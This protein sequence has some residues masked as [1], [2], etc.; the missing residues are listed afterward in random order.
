MLLCSICILQINSLSSLTLS[1]FFIF[2]LYLSV[3]SLNEQHY[4]HQR[5]SDSHCSEITIARFIKVR[6]F[7]RSSSKSESLRLSTVHDLDQQGSTEICAPILTSKC[8]KDWTTQYTMQVDRERQVEQWL[9]ESSY[10]D[11]GYFCILDGAAQLK[12][13]WQEQMCD[14]KPN[15]PEQKTQAHYDGTCIPCMQ[16][17]TRA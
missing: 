8:P 17:R 12:T 5:A 11:K 16:R 3:L 7:Q 9:R 13:T 15:E 1:H 2:I 6:L 14:L 4:Y 10:K